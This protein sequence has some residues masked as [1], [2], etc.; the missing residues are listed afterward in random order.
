MAASASHL[1]FS[2]N[3]I[4]PLAGAVSVPGAAPPPWLAIIAT[5]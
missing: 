1:D 4:T 3:A 2:A 5:Y